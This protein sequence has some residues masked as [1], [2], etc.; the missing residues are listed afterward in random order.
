M[1]PVRSGLRG[2]GA[3]VRYWAPVELAICGTGGG[4]VS[5]IGCVVKRARRFD[6]SKVENR[7][8]S[9]QG[10]CSKATGLVGSRVKAMDSTVF[11]W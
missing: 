9:L 11:L 8:Y 1:I 7:L 10:G 2:Y 6:V 3:A 5:G 4:M